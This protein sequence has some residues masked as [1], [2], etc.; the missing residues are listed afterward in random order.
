[1]AAVLDDEKVCT[2]CGRNQPV[3]RFKRRSRAQG[4]RLSWCRGCI[5]ESARQ[6]TAR[7][8][9]AALGQAAK[10][11]R[12]NSPASRVEAVIAATCR[13]LGGV[14]AVASRIAEAVTS[15][16]VNVALTAAIFVMKLLTAQD[17]LR[18]ASATSRNSIPTLSDDERNERVR[19]HLI[20]LLTNEPESLA[21]ALRLLGW[22]VELPSTESQKRPH[23]SSSLHSTQHH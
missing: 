19:Q 13:R 11:I 18:L 4:Q 22:R 9:T 8:R 21:D 1:M 10:Y 7:K 15:S 23:A 2:H 5:N 20:E 16:N 6:C 14:E 17:R 3:T 12:L